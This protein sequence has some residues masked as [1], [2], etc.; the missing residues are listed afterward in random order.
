MKK[1][2]FV[3]HISNPIQINDRLRLL[4]MCF[5]FEKDLW[6]GFGR[7]LVGGLFHS[8][9]FIE[10]KNISKILSNFDYLRILCCYNAIEIVQLNTPTKTK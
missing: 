1:C 8:L 2:Y 10:E 6:P 4:C 9:K 3:D 5:F 7:L